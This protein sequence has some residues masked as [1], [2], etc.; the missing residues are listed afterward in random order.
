MELNVKLGISV[1]LWDEND[2]YCWN[3]LK[4]KKIIDEDHAVIKHAG[5]IF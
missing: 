2:L 4:V 1:K 5:N 3:A